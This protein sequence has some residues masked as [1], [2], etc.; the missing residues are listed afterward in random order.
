MQDKRFVYFIKFGITGLS[1]LF[2]DFLVTWFFKDVLLLQKFLANAI[3]FTVA[4]INNYFIN[5]KWTF[6]SEQKIPRQ[7]VIFFLA[8]LVGLTLNTLVVYLFNEVWLLNFYLSK[9]IAVAIVFI[10]N[11]TVNY[12]FVFKSPKTCTPH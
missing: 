9:I 2:L 10:W 6:K 3:G 4:V 1:G 5:R 12:F 11:F 7:L 8:S